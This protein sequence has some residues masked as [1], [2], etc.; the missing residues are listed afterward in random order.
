GCFKWFL[1]FLLILLLLLLFFWL[2]RNCNGIN[3]HGVEGGGALN[4]G[5]NSWVQED[6]NVGNEGG[7]YDPYNPY[8][9]KPTL[10]EHDAILPPQQGVLPPIDENPDIIPGNPSII[11]N[12]LNI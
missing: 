11:G 5:D 10:P 1:W 7:I 6:P 8:Q 3:N 9:P 12:R 2:F 4:D